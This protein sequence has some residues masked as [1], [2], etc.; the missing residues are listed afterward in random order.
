[1]RQ[2]ATIFTSPIPLFVRWDGPKGSAPCQINPVCGWSAD[3]ST[4]KQIDPRHSRAAIE[5]VAWR[6]RAQGLGLS[7]ERLVRA[8]PGTGPTDFVGLIVRVER[9]AAHGT[10]YQER[11]CRGHT[12]RQGLQDRVQGLC[13]GE[14]RSVPRDAGPDAVSRDAFSEAIATRLRA[15]SRDTG[16]PDRESAAA[17]S[18]PRQGSEDGPGWTRMRDLRITRP[19]SRAPRGP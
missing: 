6:G 9:L 11:R 1:M 15:H 5:P 2:R 17:N 8:T 18:A 12:D 3:W 4:Q 13:F 16:R 10:G 7:T 14:P 19:R